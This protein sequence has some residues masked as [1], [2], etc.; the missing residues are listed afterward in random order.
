MNF[1]KSITDVREIFYPLFFWIFIFVIYWS[2]SWFFIEPVDSFIYLIPIFVILSIYISFKFSTYKIYKPFGLNKK[3]T[4]LIPSL[5]GFGSVIFYWLQNINNFGRDLAEVRQEHLENA[6]VGIQDTI[7]S[8]LFPLLI[9][10]FI[11]VNFNNLKYKKTINLLVIFSCVIFIPINGGRINF[12]VFGTLYAAIFF[13]N[14][15]E[16]IIKKWFLNLVKFILYFIVLSFISSLYGLVRISED[17]SQVLNNLYTL[18]YI[19]NDVLMGLLKL[20]NNIGLFIIFFINIFYDYTGGIV[21]YLNIFL[22]NFYKIDYRTYGFYNFNFLD[23]FET[24]NFTKSHDDID[25]LYLPY[26]IRHNVWASFIRD[27]MIDFGLIGTFLVLIIL[28]SIMFHARKYI[29]QSYSAQ[30]LFFLLFAFLIFTPFHSLFYLTR[31]YGITFFI[32]LFGFFRF[33]LFR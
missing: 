24:I 7:Y 11:V 22:D 26:D 29:A 13:F 23:R 30:V 20:P 12:L 18:Q 2:F 15:H 28:S 8:F 9:Y 27:F 3:N 6:N 1:V 5:L 32:A 25:N 33:K 14:N 21:Y 31:V 16:K 19:N 17:N 4:F 10:S